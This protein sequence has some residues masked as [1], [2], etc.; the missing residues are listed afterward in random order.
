[1][2]MNLKDKLFHLVEDQE[3]EMI[4]I[5]RH[6]HQHPELSFQESNTAEYIKNFYHN[7]D[8]SLTQPISDAHAIVVEI[9]GDKPGK[10]IALRADFDA[11]PISEETEVPFK[12]QNEGVMHACGHD[13]HTAILLGVAEIVNEHRHLLKGNVVFI[14][15]YG[16]EIM[17]GGS[18]EMIDDGCLQDVDKIYGTH[19]WSGYPSGTIYSRPGAIMASPDEFSITIKGSGGHGAKPHETIDPIVIMAESVR[20]I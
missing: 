4:Q 11:L 10:T 16:E 14:F 15:Q 2:F 18:Q 12:S 9:K 8:V 17:P 6:L 7:K 1:M 5:R 20:V 19:L 13:G 3:Q